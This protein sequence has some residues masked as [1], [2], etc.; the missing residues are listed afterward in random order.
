MFTQAKVT[1]TAEISTIQYQ[2]V[3]YEDILPELFLDVIQR[4][5]SN[6]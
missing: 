4:I 2:Q 1:S 6:N 5:I 3:H